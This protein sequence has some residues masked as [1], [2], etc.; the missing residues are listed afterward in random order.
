MAQILRCCGSGVGQWLQLQL[1][2][3]LG[4]SICRG[5]GPRKGKK[6]DQKKKKNLS[7]FSLFL[8]EIC[9]ALG[10]VISELIKSLGA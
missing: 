6:K 2:P 5:S 1:D 8:L 9:I 4:T 10:S 7:L 3:S